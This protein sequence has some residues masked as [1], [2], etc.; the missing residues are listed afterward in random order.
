[1][2]FKSILVGNVF[3]VRWETIQPGDGPRL[4]QAVQQAQNL[5][6]SKLIYIAVAPNAK[7]PD[8]AVRPEIGR[9]LDSLH[10]YCSSLHLVIEQRGFMGAAHRTV[11]AGISM[12][13]AKRGKKMGVYATLED[14]LADCPNVTVT[15]ELV[16]NTA[17]VRGIT[18]D[19]D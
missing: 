5:L 7:P 18:V 4:V 8:D 17:R 2:S 6:K 16:V 19:Q 11:A 10:E 3:L 13:T 15:R 12:V 1:M 14:A 9:A